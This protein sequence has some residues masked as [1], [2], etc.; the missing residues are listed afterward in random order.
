MFSFLSFIAEKHDY[1]NRCDKMMLLSVF[2][3]TY[4]NSPSRLIISAAVM[5]S[6]GLSTDQWV[7]P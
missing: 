3:G 7:R 4:T 1:G 5:A 2:Y 6:S